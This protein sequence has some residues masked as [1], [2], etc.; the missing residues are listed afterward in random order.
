MCGMFL[1]CS[2]LASIK[3]PVEGDAPDLYSS[4]MQTLHAGNTSPPEIAAPPPFP[5]ILDP[6]LII[7]H[8]YKLT[9]QY[10]ILLIFEIAVPQW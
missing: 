2:I 7:V 1:N 3:F 10:D 5:K 9:K 8:Y 4:S 6:P